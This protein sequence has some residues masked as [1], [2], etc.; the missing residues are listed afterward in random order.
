MTLFFRLLCSFLYT[1]NPKIIRVIAGKSFMKWNHSRFLD[2]FLLFFSFFRVIRFFKLLKV[3]VSWSCVCVPTPV[4]KELALN[5]SPPVEQ[6]AQSRG[7]M[8]D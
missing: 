2:L 1:L 7:A 8:H 5:N 4:S 3:H 6:L